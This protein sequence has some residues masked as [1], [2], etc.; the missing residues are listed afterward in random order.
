[1]EQ[2]ECDLIGKVRELS[3]TKFV[4]RAP[5]S[6]REGKFSQENIADLKALGI[7]G[8]ALPKDIGGLGVS[9]RMTA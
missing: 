3:R 9:H 5:M 7:P 1:M 6:D 4:E 8:M 2:W